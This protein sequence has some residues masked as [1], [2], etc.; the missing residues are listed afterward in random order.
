M[1]HYSDF[2]QYSWILNKSRALHLQPAA[3]G[4]G[5]GGPAFSLLCLSI[6]PALPVCPPQMATRKITIKINEFS[7]VAFFCFFFFPSFSSFSFNLWKDFPWRFTR[8]LFSPPLVSPLC[9]PA[10]LINILLIPGYLKS[11]VFPPPWHLS[12]APG[13]RSMGFC[14]LSLLLIP[15]ISV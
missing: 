8:K 13:H 11:F 3:E 6:T 9:R 5:D 12:S 1:P 14:L 7:C 10:L 2:T 15:K 4:P